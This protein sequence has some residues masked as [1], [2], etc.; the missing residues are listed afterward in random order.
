[1]N[2]KR[3]LVCAAHFYPHVGGSEKYILELYSRMTNQFKID[4]LVSDYQKNQSYEKYKG[5]NIYRLDSWCLLGNTYPVPKL[6]IDNY[7]ILKNILKNDDYLFINTH[8]RFFV[9]S[10]LGFLMSKFKR[11]KLIHTEHGTS[12]AIYDNRFVEI[13]SSVYDKT[14]G[15]LIVKS[16]EFSIGIS[17]ASNKFLKQLKAKKVY[18]VPNGVDTSYFKKTPSNLR[19]KLGFNED[20]ILITYIGRLTQPKGVQDLIK[21]FNLLNIDKLNLQLLI[22]GDGACFHE[23]KKISKNNPN[24]IFLGHRSDVPEILSITDIFVNPSHYEGLPT[25][26]LEAASVGV[27]IVATNVGGTGEMF[28]EEMGYLVDKKDYNGIYNSMKKIIENRSK[29]SNTNNSSRD[30]ILNNYSWEKSS[31][32]FITIIKENFYEKNII[33]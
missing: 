20:D 14:M 27:P 3:I 2:K 7:K 22:V 8:T 18:L 4:I 17:K 13:L 33:H 30:Y 9:I 23:L 12:A 19:S 29:F 25:S 11:Y 6:S 5:L 24:I 21:A 32:E 15:S 26:V 31:E 28:I 1:M 10:I 16:S